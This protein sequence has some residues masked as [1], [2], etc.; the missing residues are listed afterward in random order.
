M[1]PPDE[2]L[3]DDDMT[4][5]G[6][7]PAGG[8]GGDADGTDS[9]GTDGDATDTTDGD[10]TDSDGTDSRRHRRRRHRRHRRRRDGPTATPT[11]PT[12]TPRLHRRR[13]VLSALDLLS[14]DAQ[15]FLDKVWASRVHLH[16]T[17]PA[18]LVGLLSLD[19]A[20]HLLTSTA[21]R[22]PSIRLARDG[23]GAAGVDVHPRR[24]ARRQAAHRAG[25]PAQGAGRVRRRRDRRLP[26][27]APLLAAADPSWSP[28]SSWSSATPARPTPTSRR[29]ASQGFA[30]HSDSHD[31][32]VFQT[33]GSKR[34]EV[35]TPDGVEDVLLEPGL[36]MYLPTGTPHAARAQDTRLPARDP[37]HQPAHLA[38]PASS[39]ASGRCWPTVPDEHLPAGYLDAPEDARRRPRRPARGPRRRGTPRRRRPPRCTPRS[40]AS[41]PAAAR[42]CP[43]GSGT[44]S[45][46][47]DLDRHHPAAPPARATRAC[48][49]TAATGSTCCSATARSTYPPGSGRRSRRSAPGPSS[50]PADLADVLDPQS[51]LVLC[52]RL[53]REGLLEVV[54]MILTD[55]G[56]PL[57][58][59]QRAARRAGRRHRL[60]RARVPAAR[61][62]RARGATTRSATPGCPATSARGCGGASAETGVRILLVRRP[63]RRAAQGARDRVRGVRR[64]APAVARARRPHRP[65]RR[66]RPRPGGAARGSVTPGWRRRPSSVY[67]VCTHGRHDACCAE[68]G[69]PVAAALSRGPS[70]GHVGG[71]AHRRRPVRRQPAGAAARPLLRA[72]RRRRPRSRSPASHEAGELDLDHLRGRSGYAMPVQA[73]EIALRRELGE[74]RD[75]ALRL[76]RRRRDGR[77]P[78]RCSTWPARPGRCGSGPRPGRAARG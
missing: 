74:T 1:T 64:P 18:R 10:A 49:S 47:R 61:A 40:A 7:G 60:D 38:R 41:S 70:R 62:R 15:T 65:A 28:S 75:D 69:R 42:G 56:L 36:S 76:T 27:P 71:L 59:R 58:G 54:A 37:R 77:R 26:G 23:V 12:A 17:D 48:C 66:A 4:T 31:V 14:G 24:D 45:P 78:R 44:C 43:A 68:R 53:I 20:D 30:V 2:P 32:F 25:R 29:P 67:C 63:G 46:S 72:A 11:A 5:S 33:E 22:T 73:A 34:W 35:H 19:D 39:A 8:A 55:R 3:N 50:R 21:I 13:R 9:D 51:R 57:R 6:A 52:R 16:R